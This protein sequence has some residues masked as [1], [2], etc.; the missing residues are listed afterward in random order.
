M[1]VF[2]LSFFFDCSVDHRDRHVLPHPFPT[3]RSSDPA[4][5]ALYDAEYD[6]A[7]IEA[8]S[9]TY[10]DADVEDAYRISMAVTELK[11]ARGR[12]VKGHKIGLDRKST[13]LNSSH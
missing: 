9:A 8:I 10:P 4:A 13:R 2:I 11:V 3:R 6:R 5:Q 12:T 1:C 7:P